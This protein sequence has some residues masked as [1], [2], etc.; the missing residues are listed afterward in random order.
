[1]GSVETERFSKIKIIKSRFC[2]TM[3]NDELE[4]ILRIAYELDVNI[5]HTYVIDIFKF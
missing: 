3:S 5:D 1:V 4:L 2:S